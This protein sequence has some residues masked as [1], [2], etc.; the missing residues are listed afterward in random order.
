MLIFSKSLLF[1]FTGWYTVEQRKYF[2]AMDTSQSTNQEVAAASS[3]PKTN[4][5]SS[6]EFD[7]IR[8]DESETIEAKQHHYPL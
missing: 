6:D 2:S 3:Q 7:F 1:R 4:Y 8:T 5:V